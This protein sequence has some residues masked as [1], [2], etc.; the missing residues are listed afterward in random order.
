MVRRL[1]QMSHQCC[2]KVEII[3]LRSA[4]EKCL[5]QALLCLLTALTL[6]QLDNFVLLR[7]LRKQ[8]ILINTAS[9]FPT[10]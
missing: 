6:W 9:G 3:Q 4:H 10:K 5:N 8:A 7:S 1:N 2:L